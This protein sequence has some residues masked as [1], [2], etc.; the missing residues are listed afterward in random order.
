MTSMCVSLSW[1][2]LKTGPYTGTCRGRPQVGPTSIGGVRQ[3]RDLARP[4]DRGAQLALVQRTGARDPAR[5]DLG[6]LR[7]ERRQQ[8]H[9]LVVDVVDLLD[10]DLADLAPA[11]H[12]TALLP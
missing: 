4:H 1:A 11:E 5:Q 6:A 8:L 3:Q 2:G 12:R 10:A 7:H 9:V